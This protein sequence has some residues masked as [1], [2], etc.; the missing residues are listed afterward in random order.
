[1][2]LRDT[3]PVHLGSGNH[4]MTSVTSPSRLEATFVVVC[5]PVI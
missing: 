5:F 1:M 4:P 2:Y 3:H